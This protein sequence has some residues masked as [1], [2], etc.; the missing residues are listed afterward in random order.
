MKID[1][2]VFP[3][4]LSGVYM[5]IMWAVCKNKNKH[6]LKKAFVYR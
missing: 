6:D 2:G 5:L 1:V 3:S 4:Q